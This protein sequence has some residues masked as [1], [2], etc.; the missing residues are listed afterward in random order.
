MATASNVP[1]S[2]RASDPAQ[3]ALVAARFHVSAT[4]SGTPWVKRTDCAPDPPPDPDAA[5]EAESHTIWPSLV[6]ITRTTEGPNGSSH[7]EEDVETA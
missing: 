6:T 7:P 5:H 4:S 2:P 1:D 3:D